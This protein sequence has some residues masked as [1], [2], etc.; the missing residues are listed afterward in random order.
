MTDQF[1]LAVLFVVLHVI[2]N[3]GFDFV[4]GQVFRQLLVASPLRNGGV[5]VR[6]SIMR[7]A[8]VGLLDRFGQTVDRIRQFVTLSL[9]V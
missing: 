8:H 7:A 4:A 6:R 9:D 5:C 3:R 1:P 2:G